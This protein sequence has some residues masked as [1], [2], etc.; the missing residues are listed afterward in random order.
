MKHIT[1]PTYDLTLMD[2]ND[3]ILDEAYD[4]QF[5]VAD[6]AYRMGCKLIVMQKGKGYIYQWDMGE[7]QFICAAIYKS[8]KKVVLEAIEAFPH[9]YYEFRQVRPQIYKVSI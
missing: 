8:R 3:T 4:D 5:K 7:D 6:L 2:I 1:F 9:C